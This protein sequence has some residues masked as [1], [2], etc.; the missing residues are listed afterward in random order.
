VK[1]IINEALIA[2]AIK[3][4][5]EELADLKQNPRRGRPGP[6]G[7]RGIPGLIGEEGPAGPRGAQGLKGDIGPVGPAGP[8]GEHGLIGEQGPQGIQG[9]QGEVGPQGEQ[10]IQGEQGEQG[11]RGE[12]GPQGLQGP[13]GDVGP[14]GPQGIQGVQGP[15]GDK[16]DKGDPGV[17]GQQGPKGDRGETGAQGPQGL[18]GEI[19]PQGLQ[20]PKGD[21]GDKGDRGDVG[22]QGPAG[23][24]GVTPDVEPIIKRAQ[25]DFN[26]WREN[27]NKS[28]AS[29]GGGGLGEKDVIAIARQY[30]GGGGGSG[31]VDSAA[32]IS[33]I[34]QYSGTGTV[35]SA[36]LSALAQSLVPLEDSTYDL[37]SPTKKWKDLHLSGNTINLGAATISTGSGGGIQL[38]SADGS[39]SKPQV[40]NTTTIPGTV[41]LDMRDPIGDTSGNYTESV[42]G[43][44]SAGPFGEDLV[45]VYDCMEPQ[46]SI[47]SLDLGAL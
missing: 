22:P 26:R 25:D 39:V 43:D 47:R 46:G 24:D 19:G 11:P 7:E 31:T 41:N 18:R 10:G 17:D 30:G 2:V 23:K 8:Q 13:R 16:G 36:Y 5:K 37:G 20:G 27:I 3:Q 15:K 34:Q 9:I 21:K 14:A 1:P 28:L 12:R 6:Q 29:I 4:L 40:S 45:S 32:T 38:A 33:L 44:Q 35:D 42:F